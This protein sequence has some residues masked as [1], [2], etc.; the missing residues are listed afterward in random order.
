[1]QSK[2]SKYSDSPDGAVLGVPRSP[3][4]SGDRV[5]HYEDALQQIGFGKAQIQVIC[6]AFLLLFTVIDETIGISF[7]MPAAKCDLSLSASDRGLLSG[8]FSFG[9]FLKCQH[10][11]QSNSVNYFQVQ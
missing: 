10:A 1:M 4:P 5:V 9:E 8:M 6:V 2:R 3:S 11:P 7:I